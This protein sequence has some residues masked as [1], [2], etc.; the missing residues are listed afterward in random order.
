M[1]YWISHHFHIDKEDQI[2]YQHASLLVKQCRL[3]TSYD[4]I[5]PISYS[6]HKS[7]DHHVFCHDPLHLAVET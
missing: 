5:I 4:G 2:V 1:S 3:L 7:K 6:M